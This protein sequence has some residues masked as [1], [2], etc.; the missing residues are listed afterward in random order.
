MIYK[1]NYK[2]LRKLKFEKSAFKRLEASTTAYLKFKK[3][4]GKDTIIYISKNKDYIYT[5]DEAAK[6]YYFN[7]DQSKIYFP[8]LNIDLIPEYY[9]IKERLYLAESKRRYKTR[10]DE[11]NSKRQF[12]DSEIIW[13]KNF[14]LFADGY[15]NLVLTELKY[16][17]K[18][19]GADLIVD[20]VKE[21]RNWL[22]NENYGKNLDDLFLADYIDHIIKLMKELKILDNDDSCILTDRNM[23]PLSALI[24]YLITNRTNI[25]YILRK[26]I[27][28]SENNLLSYFNRFLGKSYKRVSAKGYYY[29]S[30]ECIVN[31]YFNIL[32]S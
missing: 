6:N 21:Y 19:G 31:Q 29:K 1:Y 20:Q 7:R 16:F 23:A 3:I 2:N 4:D 5:N 25:K 10:F 15:Y 24:I 18:Q 11:R 30:S 26:N 12:K 22:T 8:H 14:N 28:K 32:F 17:E 13:A 9:K 27:N